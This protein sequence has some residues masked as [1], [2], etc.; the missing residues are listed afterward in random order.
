MKYLILI[1][2]L[3]AGC[4]HDEPTVIVDIDPDTRICQL[5]NT[6]QSHIKCWGKCGAVSGVCKIR[7]RLEG[8]RDPW[9]NEGGSDRRRD[10]ER[11]SELEYGCYCD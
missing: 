3:L 7:W 1:V 6:G 10:E 9:H 8:T 5:D 2:L 11:D 4:N